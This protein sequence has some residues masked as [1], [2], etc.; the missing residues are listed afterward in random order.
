VTIIRLENSRMMDRDYVN[1]LTNAI[2]M[3]ATK[4]SDTIPNLDAKFSFLPYKFCDDGLSPDKAR[5]FSCIPFV[6]DGVIHKDL[7]VPLY[8][9]QMTKYDIKVLMTL[10]KI[11]GHADGAMQVIQ[12]V[13]QKYNQMRGP[14]RWDSLAEDVEYVGSVDDLSLCDLQ[15]NLDVHVQFDT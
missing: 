10:F 15:Y 4:A 7:P 9:G 6:H 8:A 11:N 1:S 5:L 13:L 3:D 14:N 2:L 12:L